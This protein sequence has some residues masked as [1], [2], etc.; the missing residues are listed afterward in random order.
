MSE[1]LIIYNI[2]LK[3][4]IIGARAHR[5]RERERETERE[6]ERESTRHIH[7]EPFRLKVLLS[8]RH[9]MSKAG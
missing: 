4:Y 1:T 8:K 6:R 5:E 3:F 7:F 9:A 2:I